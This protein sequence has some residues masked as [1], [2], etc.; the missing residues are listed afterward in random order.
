[1]IDVNE[2]CRLLNSVAPDRYEVVE[3]YIVCKPPP[4]FAKSPAR[5]RVLDSEFVV[6]Y[7]ADQHTGAMT[8]R[9]W[10]RYRFEAVNASGLHRDVEEH[11]TSTKRRAARLARVV[12]LDEFNVKSVL[13][14]GLTIT[15]SRSRV[16]G[17]VVVEVDGPAEGHDD[18]FEPNGAPLVRV[19]LNDDQIFG[20]PLEAPEPDD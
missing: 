12:E 8:E 1:M 16:D 20:E 10:Y 11:I 14:E 3:N 17:T 4:G 15:A 5:V 7:V 18:D 9:R 19:W 6:L 2:V 13:F